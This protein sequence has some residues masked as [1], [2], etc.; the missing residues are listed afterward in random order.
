MP[1]VTTN[2]A[3]RLK[4]LR[5]E[6]GWP[7]DELAVRSGLSRATLSRVENGEVSPTAEALAKLCRAYG[8]TMS[9]LILMA[10]ENFVAHV[11]RDMQDVWRD[12]TAG[13]TRRMVSPPTPS[14]SG[15]VLDCFLEPGTRIHYDAPQMPGTEHHLVMLEG[16]L[17][18]DVEGRLHA[19]SP[20]DSLR[21]KLHGSSGFE[22]PP[23]QGARYILVLI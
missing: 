3:E 11:P 8:M 21:Y 2:L 16:A 7:L 6:R 1:D 19:L 23:E 13:F 18:V 9:R 22:T 12:E 17:T 5:A 15:E 10:E 4:H 14:L 20:G